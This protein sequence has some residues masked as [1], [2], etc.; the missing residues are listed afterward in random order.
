MYSRA[1]GSSLKGFGMN[2]LGGQLRL[3]EV[4]TGQPTTADVQLARHSNRD[5]L[6][7]AVQH[8]DLQC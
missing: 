6:S 5:R 4:A 8:I 3:V 1:A 7:A 2:L